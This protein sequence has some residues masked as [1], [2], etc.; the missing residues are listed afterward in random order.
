M[1]DRWTQW[2][3]GP[4]QLL[5]F[6]VEGYTEPL[7]KTSVKYSKSLLLVT[8][9]EGKFASKGYYFFIPPYLL[10]SISILVSWDSQ[11]MEKLNNEI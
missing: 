2:A 4:T 5:W 3:N 8:Q 9:Q 10:L 7:Y 6:K 1:T 11:S